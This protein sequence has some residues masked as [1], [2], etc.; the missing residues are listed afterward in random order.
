ML[1]GDFMI[2][3]LTTVHENARSALERGGLAPPSPLGLY[4][5]GTLRRR[6]AAA[7]R[8][9]R[10]LRHSH[11]QSSPPCRTRHPQTIKCHSERSEESR[12]APGVWRE[13]EQGEIPRFARNDSQFQSSEGSP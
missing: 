8:T 3:G 13:K 5:L 2:L 9:P 6:P 1:S 4:A 11:F 7:G 10:C 12:S